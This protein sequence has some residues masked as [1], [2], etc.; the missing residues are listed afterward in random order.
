MLRSE[1]RRR[2]LAW[3][4]ASPLLLGD[5]LITDPKD[6]INVFDF[7]AVARKV[8]P[9]A[10]WGYL[11][12]GVDDDATLRANREGFSKLYLRPR[13]LIDVSKAD[14]RT[15]VL[16]LSWEFPI[17]LSPIGN[18]MAFHPEA[19]MA[20]ARA[21][22]S[23]RMVQVLS[24]NANTSYEKVSEALGQPAW[25]QLYV[26]ARPEVTEKIVKRVESAGCPVMC[27]TVDTTAGRRTETFER[28][29]RLDTREC[30]TCHGEPRNPFMRKPMF[31]GIDTKG[32]VTQTSTLTWDRV[33]QI[34]DSTK[35]KVVIKGI[36]TAEDAKLCRDAGFDG[37]L[38]S[39]HGGRAGESGRGTI[40]CLPEVVEAAGGKVPVML[41][42]GI[43][44]GADAF[45]AIA[46]GASAVFIGR[47]YVWALAA[48]GQPG[49]ERVI[50]IMQ[51][52]LTLIMKQCGARSIP[53][54]KGS[55]VAYRKT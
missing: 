46:L 26:G 34:R 4:A 33:R 1:S 52:E 48:F 18:T 15:K 29:R 17:G 54:I 42:G 8:L 6:A 13:R 7:E 20:V 38:V 41:D 30:K 43:R 16:G 14:L 19:E 5:E 44:R 11:A 35:M 45:K 39:N 37:I 22:N 51:T 2:F 32:L 28:F 25:F 3:A 47:P 40:E 12:T 55:S 27:I 24:I 10:H 36:E 31:A 53:E 50:D 9:A 49:V 23:R 21:A